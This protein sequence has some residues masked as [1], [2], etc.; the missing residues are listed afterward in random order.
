MAALLMQLIHR[1]GLFELVNR[2]MQSVALLE[3]SY[4]RRIPAFVNVLNP[5]IVVAV[6]NA[7]NIR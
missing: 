6:L 5:H 4:M 7:D 2:H 1:S 3:I